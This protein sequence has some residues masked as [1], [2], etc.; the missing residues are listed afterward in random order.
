MEGSQGALC[1]RAYDEPLGFLTPPNLEGSQ[2]AQMRFYRSE[3]FIVQGEGKGGVACLVHPP[4][5]SCNPCPPV[6]S[7]Q[8]VGWPAFHQS[9]LHAS[10]LLYDFDFDG[11]RDILVTTFDGEVRGPCEALQLYNIQPINLNPNTFEPSRRFHPLV[12]FTLVA[13]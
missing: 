3:R 6:M 11:V 2:G 13:I 9:L 1:I 4:V 12:N 8:A 7:P 5:M 10:P